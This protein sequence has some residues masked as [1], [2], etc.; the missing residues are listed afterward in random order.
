MLFRRRLGWTVLFMSMT[1]NPQASIY[2][3]PHLSAQKAW[4]APARMDLGF[5]GAIPDHGV[6]NLDALLQAQP[7]VDDSLTAEH[8]VLTEQLPGLA[9]VEPLLDFAKRNMP[10]FS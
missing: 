1:W 8:Q 10:F 4:K 7:M 3:F 2:T 6:L 5:I 9:S